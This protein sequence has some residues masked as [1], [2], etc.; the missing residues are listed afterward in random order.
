[1]NSSSPVFE[2]LVR[3]AISACRSEKKK[4]AETT[5]EMTRRLHEAACRY[6]DRGLPGEAE[7]M[8]RRALSI[9]EELLGE[10][11]PQVAES[12]LSL[13]ALYRTE[14]RLALAEPLVR[15][16]LAIRQKIRGPGHESVADCLDLLVALYRAMNRSADAQLL[17][18]RSA[19]I[20]AFLAA[21]EPHRHEAVVA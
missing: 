18:A 15:R 13:A 11:H 8:H 1:M 9:R 14:G 7:E 4:Q 17:A 16:A 5:L 21:E 2:T 19:D 20:R 10:L 3:E 12:L 6:A